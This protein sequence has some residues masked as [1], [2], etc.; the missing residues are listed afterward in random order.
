[1]YVPI[2]DLEQDEH[3]CEGPR[4]RRTLRQL[5]HRPAREAIS[6]HMHVFDDEKTALAVVV[7]VGLDCCCRLP[8]AAA[9]VNS[10]IG[11][12]GFF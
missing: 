8:A 12:S 3:V 9:A 11:K 10:E 4:D 7:H 6:E 2:T 5:L 1:M